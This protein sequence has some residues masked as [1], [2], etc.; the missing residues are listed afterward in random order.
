MKGTS[1]TV[2]RWDVKTRAWDSHAFSKFLAPAHSKHSTNEVGL[3]WPSAGD[4]GE[5]LSVALIS[6][7]IQ[8]S[9]SSLHS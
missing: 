4:G 6:M 9:L 3:V 5:A 7:R 8:S 1:G 2:S